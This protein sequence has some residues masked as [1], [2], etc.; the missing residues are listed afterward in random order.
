MFKG[1]EKLHKNVA[2]G[3]KVGICLERISHAF[4][5]VYILNTLV[6]YSFL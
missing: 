2:L 1:A 6:Y 5:F 3:V 4:G